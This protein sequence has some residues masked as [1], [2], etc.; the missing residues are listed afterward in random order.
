MLRILWKC[1]GKKVI[2]TNQIMISLLVVSAMES[3]G[4]F[5]F[6]V[7]IFSAGWKIKSW[8]GCCI[9]T[10]PVGEALAAILQGRE[11]DGASSRG[12]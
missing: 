10:D 11:N 8:E 7:L 9:L 3:Q 2:K 6:A 4:R 1:S 12:T 5:E